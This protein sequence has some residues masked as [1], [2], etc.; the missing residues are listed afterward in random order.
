M[1]RGL[2]GLGL[3]VPLAE[4]TSIGEAILGDTVTEKG[5]RV[6]AKMHTDLKEARLLVDLVADQDE[7][8]LVSRRPPSISYLPSGSL[9]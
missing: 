2:Y 1:Y 7:K 3:A 9:R 4:V 5:L 6:C 8:I